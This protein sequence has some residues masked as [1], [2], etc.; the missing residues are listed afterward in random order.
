MISTDFQIQKEKINFEPITLRD[1]SL[2]DK[3]Q[4]C[5][6][7]AKNPSDSCERNFANLFMWRNLYKTQI[8]NLPDYTLIYNKLNNILMFPI[9]K[10]PSPAKLFEI[11][12]YFAHKTN[13]LFIYDI[14]P[15]YVQKNFLELSK[16]FEIGEDENEFDYIYDLTHLINLNGALLRKKHNLIRQFDKLYPDAYTQELNTQNAHLAFDFMLNINRQKEILPTFGGLK[17]EDDALICAKENFEFLNLKGILLF[18]QKDILAGVA[19]FSEINPQIYTIHFEKCTPSF[20]G[21][22]QKLVWLEACKIKELGASKMN[23][24]QDLGI[25]NL[26]HAKRSLDP[27]YTYSR[28]FC[29]FQKFPNLKDF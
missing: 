8:A 18:L 2:S 28:N 5:A 19:I 23:R 14:P 20:K 22:T 16:Y 1:I 29:T 3:A 15:S 11:S 10:E 21:A 17:N 12:K 24:E 26:R 25:E 9:G 4:V 27:L 7:I 6:Q 13:E